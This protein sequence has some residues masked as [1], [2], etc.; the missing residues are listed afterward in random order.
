MLRPLAFAVA[1]LALAGCRP[2]RNPLA[3][4][5][6]T[7]VEVPRL[8]ADFNADARATRMILLISPT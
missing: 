3:L 5:E 7:A 2:A 6:L 8:Q 4:T 1:A